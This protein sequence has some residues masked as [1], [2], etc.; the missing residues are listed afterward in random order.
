MFFLLPKQHNV[1]ESYSSQGMLFRKDHTIIVHKA[2]IVIQPLLAPKCPL[3]LTLPLKYMF[4]FV[5][6]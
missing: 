2:N 1:V 4:V 6:E 3:T 5:C